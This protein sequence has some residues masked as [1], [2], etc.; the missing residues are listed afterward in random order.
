MA[1]AA[2]THLPHA[3]NKLYENRAPLV[4]LVV[5]R[6]VAKPDGNAQESGPLV[7]ESVWTGTTKSA[8]ANGTHMQTECVHTHIQAQTV[9]QIGAQTRASLSRSD[10]KTLRANERAAASVSK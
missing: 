10:R 8:N 6:S 4:V 1:C 2:R 5:R 9:A 7:E 3:I